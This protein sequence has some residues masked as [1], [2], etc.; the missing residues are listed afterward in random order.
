M[1][2]S[3]SGRALCKALE[4]HCQTVQAAEDGVAMVRA[5]WAAGHFRRGS[6]ARRE[7]GRRTATAAVKR[8]PEPTYKNV[9][10]PSHGSGRILGPPAQGYAAAR[11]RTAQFLAERPLPDGYTPARVAPKLVVP[12]ARGV[13]QG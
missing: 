10:V 6:H 7:A 5:V 11:N 3:A 1:A 9:L 2:A 12:A 8:G 13:P 4:S